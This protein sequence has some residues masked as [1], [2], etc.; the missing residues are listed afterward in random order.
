MLMKFL[1]L[2]LLSCWVLG[3]VAEEAANEEQ[4]READSSGTS[5]IE[6]VMGASIDDASAL[7][8]A[9]AASE[10]DCYIDTPAW[11]EYT[12]G[13]CFH[14]GTQASWASF[15]LRPG[16]P[17]CGYVWYDHPECTTAVCNVPISPGQTISLGAYYIACATG[18]PTL[19][20]GATAMYEYGCLTC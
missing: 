15:R 17:A 11:D 19:G 18:S 2:G 12:V 14:I 7:S 5:L 20:A 3:C 6:D 10:M 9:L 4:L 8:L 16:T 1:A 13:Q